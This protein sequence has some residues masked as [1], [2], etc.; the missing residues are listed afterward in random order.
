MV[1]FVGV[2]VSWQAYLF[3]TTNIKPKRINASL[4]FD[5]Y[6]LLRTESWLNRFQ[7]IAAYR[8]TRAQ[9]LAD[10][11]MRSC[12]GYPAAPRGPWA[13]RGGVSQA[14]WIRSLGATYVRPS[15][16]RGVKLGG[17]FGAPVGEDELALQSVA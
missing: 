13:S 11:F 15:E 14:A 17:L 6:P 8:E 16:G 3:W 5:L 9:E 10:I 12:T 2:D 4:A 1:A 7:G